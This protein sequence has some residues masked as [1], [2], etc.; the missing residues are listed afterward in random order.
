MNKLKEYVLRIH[1]IALFIVIMLVTL[2]GC[3]ELSTKQDLLDYSE[4]NYGKCKLIS[5]SESEEENT[6][7]VEDNE[8]KFEYE[9]SSYMNKINIDGSYF[10]SLPS[11]KSTFTA[12][13]LSCFED[14]YS[15]KI[16][17]IENKYECNI[18]INKNF[19]PKIE[20]N[21]IMYVYNNKDKYDNVIKELCKYIKDFD[22]RKY[23]ENGVIYIKK[24]DK[25]VGQ[26]LLKDKKYQSKSEYE[27]E[28]VLNNAAQIMQ[29]DLNLDIKNPSELKFLY[30][31]TM[32]VKDIYGIEDKTLVYRIGTDTDETLKNT[33]VWHYEYRKDE[34][35]IADCTVEPY[36]HLYVTKL[37]N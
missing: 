5:S 9:T 18:E 10:G 31:E 28:W 6:V 16:E 27:Q 1:K 8:Y 24:N 37:N 23:I 30:S 32:D 15:D 35:I 36:G 2:C 22:T 17:K 21:I 34:W 33:T 25:F 4:E 19:N 20:S 13:Y 7:I 12:E 26:Y 14:K 3:G 29:Y 11:T